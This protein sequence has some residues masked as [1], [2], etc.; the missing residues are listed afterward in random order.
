MHRVFDHH[1]TGAPTTTLYA[2]GEA[3]LLLDARFGEHFFLGSPDI[4]YFISSD[5]IEIDSFDQLVT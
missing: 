2:S 1:G 5:L 4:S 3:S